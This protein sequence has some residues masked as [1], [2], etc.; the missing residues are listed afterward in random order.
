MMMTNA[1]HFQQ[2][3]Q[4]RTVLR[5]D[6][7]LPY[8]IR[9]QVHQSRVI[10]SPQSLLKGRHGRN[11]A[12]GTPLISPAVHRGFVQQVLE[13]G[14]GKIAHLPRFLCVLSERRMQTV[15]VVERAMSGYHQFFPQTPQHP[16]PS[17]QIFS[18]KNQ[19]KALAV[20]D[21]KGLSPGSGGW[22]GLR[23]PPM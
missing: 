7:H 22:S 15:M 20:D 19:Q 6:R 12:A 2:G 11:K 8:Q 5:A 4:G 18:C 17:S 16:T 9:G 23:E 21:T 1:Q 3:R 14:C 10:A 13:V